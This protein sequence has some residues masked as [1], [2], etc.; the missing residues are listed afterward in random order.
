M[1]NNAKYSFY[2]WFRRGFAAQL[3]HP[4]PLASDGAP[5]P[6]PQVAIS[7][8]IL[9]GTNKLAEVA[10]NLQLYGPG[11]IMGI[12]RRAVVKTEPRAGVTNF[13]TN[14]F[15]YIEFYDEDFPWRYSPFAPNGERL[16]PWL[17]L[18]V[19][20][21]G[22][23][24]RLGL[25]NSR[26][27]VIHIFDGALNGIFPPPDQSW[28][29]AHAH[30]NDAFSSGSGPIE[31][32]VSNFLKAEPNAGSSRL[33]SPCKLRENTNYTAFLLPAFEQGRLAGLGADQ[34]R[35]RSVALQRSSWGQPHEWQPDQW[36]IYFEWNFRTGA[37]GDFESLVRRLQPRPDLDPRIGR[38][39]MDLQDPGYNLHYEGGEDEQAGA[40]YLTGALRLPGAVE[41]PMTERTDPAAQTFM[42]HLADLVNL[43][44]DLRTQT[45]SAN[46]L[47]NPYFPE[48]T[49]NSIYDDP[50]VT[51]PFYGKYHSGQQRVT[52][53]G[54]WYNQLNLDPKYRVAA[55]LG[56]QVVQKEQESL[57]ERAWRQYGEILAVNRQLRREQLSLALSKALYKKHFQSERLST[58]DLTVLTEKLHARV[59]NGQ[60]T[61]FST[62]DQSQAV[63][64]SFL[65]P[66]YT[67]MTR[68][69]GP[70]MRRLNSRPQK[71][72]FAEKRDWASWSM[73]SA[74][75]Y[76]DSNAVFT[77][78]T[79][80]FQINTAPVVVPP[81]IKA[82]FDR[83]KPVAN[84]QTVMQTAVNL[85]SVNNSIL[86]KTEP[87]QQFAA[88]LAATIQLPTDDGSGTSSQS[89]PAEVMREIMAA[90]EFP[91]PMYKALTELSNDYLVPNLELLPADSIALLENNE[92]F[93]ESYLLGL[94]YEMGREL[95]WREF[96]TDQS[97]S[98]FTRFWDAADNLGSAAKADIR[99]IHLWP[100]QTP[101]G[102]ATHSPG[103][104]EA[105]LVLTIRGELLRKY[106]NTIVYMQRADWEDKAKGTRKLKEGTD[107][108]AFP[109]FH[110][111][112][113]P[114]IYFLGFDKTVAVA[115]GNQ[116]DPGWF[117][118]LKER[119]GEVRFGLDL[120]E[121]EDHETWDNLSWADFPLVESCVDL[122]RDLPPANILRD[123][124]AW[125]KGSGATAD[126]PASGNGNAADMASILYQKPFM[127][128]VHA[129][130]LLPDAP[131]GGRTNP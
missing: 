121:H 124:L 43:D 68:E 77:M 48:S 55:G 126:D 63:S 73:F 98:Y 99:P 35:I 8:D 57:M 84:F 69:R 101:L 21:D 109:L 59:R 91:E 89:D 104:T 3:D 93:I 10:R 24:E 122:E 64:E 28:A 100:L 112:I 113:E 105:E 72:I 26:L 71:V 83:G 119:S 131:G 34:A 52:V 114:D 30:L 45:V 20:E 50:I 60:Q 97:G 70:L 86:Q 15:P 117:F 13:E 6:L 23:Y 67:K 1:E 44:E 65:H 82:H 96:P 76:Q 39:L 36:P 74:N 120:D 53:N 87:K 130:E 19:L 90:P 118:V 78:P 92:A 27:P 95:L 9:S 11:E 128:A 32:Q 102:D 129:V 4:D 103:N 80:T 125:G 12:E 56:S 38:K 37:V 85:L 49:D 25:T 110:A 62:F 66:L 22:A 14:Y 81:L 46:F 31:T 17:V 29:W 127:V 106:P 108:L 51:P 40:V 16:R 94:N 54:Q 47:H 107:Q 111:Q 61:V 75:I 2:A 18:A 58:P 116:D 88:R 115:K 41:P 7:L 42:Q 33:L 79:G 5:G 123:G